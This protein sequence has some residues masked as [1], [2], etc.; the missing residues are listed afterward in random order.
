MNALDWLDRSFT[1]ARRGGAP[2][3]RQVWLASAPLAFVT[4]FV[5]YL[6]RVEGIRNVR[7]FLALA[8]ALAW[9]WRTHWLGRASRVLL[10]DLS[11]ELAPAPS[12]I[13]SLGIAAIAGL[14]LSPALL[15]LAGLTRAGVLGIVF[16][17]GFLVPMGLLAPSW[18]ARA[19]VDSQ[20]GARA[21]ITAYR[22]AATLRGSALL[23]HGFLLAGMLL[24]FVNLLAVAG[25]LLSAVQGLLGVEVAALES[26]LSFENDFAMLVVAVLVVLL[27]EPLRTA[28]AVA[29]LVH[30][31][32][33]RD[34]ADLRRM[35]NELS[36]GASHDRPRARSGHGRAALIGLCFAA[37][38]SPARAQAPAEVPPSDVPASMGEA[39]PAPLAPPVSPFET[40]PDAPVLEGDAALPPEVP[41][42]APE[43]LATEE[44]LAT[45]L[46]GSEFTEFNDAANG[47][48]G[49]ST[50]GD[51]PSW[52]KRLLDAILRWLQD[53]EDTG[54]SGDVTSPMP[55]PPAWVFVALA[56]ALLVAVAAF[57]LLSR[58]K[59]EALPM[60]ELAKGVSLDPRERAPE[61]HLDEAAQLAAKGLYREAFRS[62]YL[63]TLVALDRHGEIDFDPARTNWHY[64][65]QMGAS[66]RAELFRTFTQ[67]FDRKWYGDEHTTRE[68]YERGRALATSLTVPRAAP[69]AFDTLEPSGAGS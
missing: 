15:P 28:L 18:I 59:D 17:T 38:V 41:E 1:L 26:F 46:S 39:S 52:L 64:L 16:G 57:L 56:A 10:R 14:V 66:A 61:E 27:T 37:A 9:W 35:I 33:R 24:L 60:S 44:A 11:D 63:A 68:E 29:A 51:G 58:R 65:R 34:G 8:L 19:G 45:I 32:A 6:E 62:L 40:A 54:A 49:S 67:L 13:H 5:F 7:A 50:D 22:D 36:A 2:F 30:A 25:M 12:A 43:D 42:L 23:V 55:L 48:G 3:F 69:T 53:Q 21:W 31:Q 47:G 20:G 4:V